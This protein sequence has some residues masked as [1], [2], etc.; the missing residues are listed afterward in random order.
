MDGHHYHISEHGR[1][2]QA[3]HRTQC[4]FYVLFVVFSDNN[5]IMT[6]TVILCIHHSL[7]MTGTSCETLFMLAC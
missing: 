2:Y 5:C 4:I 6:L 1:L 7:L 3:R